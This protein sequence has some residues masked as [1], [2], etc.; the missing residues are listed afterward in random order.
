MK[1]SLPSSLFPSPTLPDFSS[2]SSLPSFCMVRDRSAVKAAVTRPARAV[3]VQT[4]TICKADSQELTW[5][6]TNICKSLRQNVCSFPG[7]SNAFKKPPGRHESA[8]SFQRRSALFSVFLILLRRGHGCSRKAEGLPGAAAG[9]QIWGGGNT[10]KLP[11]F[12]LHRPDEAVTFLTVV[13]LLLSSSATTLMGYREALQ[14]AAH[15]WSYS[16]EWFWMQNQNVICG[17]TWS[18]EKCHIPPL[19]STRKRVC[20]AL[21]T[22]AMLVISLVFPGLLGQ[23]ACPQRLA[24]IYFTNG[25]MCIKGFILKLLFKFPFAYPEI[26]L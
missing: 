19:P 17:F 15:R 8:E 16:N 22:S 13:L 12:K 4:T 9:Q 2:T 7:S 11:R 21:A 23:T 3:L 10:G 5:L 25:A 20:V 18:S 1:P 26:I 24:G 14:I 6:G